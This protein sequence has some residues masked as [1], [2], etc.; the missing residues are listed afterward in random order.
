MISLKDLNP[1]LLNAE[2]A[3]RGPIVIRAQDLEKQGKK[4]IYCNVGNPQ[5]LGQHP[6]SYIRQ[7]LS[8]MEYPALLESPEVNKIYP[9]D[10][11]ERAKHLHHLMPHGIGAYTQSAGMPFIRQAV[12]EFIEK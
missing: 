11:I 9:R 6:I 4:I 2:Y 10:I 8:L 1:N 12:A 5:A 7:L 3:V